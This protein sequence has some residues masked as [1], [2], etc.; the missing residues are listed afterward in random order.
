MVQAIQ[1]SMLT[2]NA[3]SALRLDGALSDSAA[4]A[5]AEPSGLGFG[6]LLNGITQPA[7]N[8]QSAAKLRHVP[9]GIS[10]L[11]GVSQALLAAA[12]VKDNAASTESAD[13]TDNADTT[14][15]A[16]DSDKDSLLTSSL[17]GQIALK[18]KLPEPGSDTDAAIGTDTD[19]V[20]EDAVT[21]LPGNNQPEADA[22]K[23]V[24]TTAQLGQ[25]ANETTDIAADLLVKANSQTAGEAA[26][27][28]VTDKTAA[29]AGEKGEAQPVAELSGTAKTNASLD[30]IGLTA[31]TGSDSY[32]RGNN[33]HDGAKAVIET[34]VKAD[35]SNIE[36]DDSSIKAGLV[37]QPAVPSDTK[38][39]GADNP[40]Q[41]AANTAT[42]TGA[43]DSSKT[44]ADTA[45]PTNKPP[46][47]ATADKTDNQA[48][49]KAGSE[50]NAPKHDTQNASQQSS[51]QQSSSQQ[52]S[53]QNNNSQQPAD[54]SVPDSSLATTK[55]AV[56]T[57]ATV[58]SDTAFGN[59]LQLA[60]QRQQAS[61]AQAL[62]R[63][64]AEQLKQSLN[65]L[66]QDAAG[67]LRERVTLMVRQNIQIAEIRLDP[68]GLGQMQI[69]IDMQQDQASV[70]FIVQQSQAKELL[71][72]QLPRLREML[73]QQGIQLTE[74]QVQQ[75]SQ[76]E[77]QLAQRD[78]NNSGRNGKHTA[79]DNQDGLAETVQ[80]K[81][82]T[83]DRLV[84]YYA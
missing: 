22:T 55:V 3:D 31:E 71:E 19:A 27:V 34:A 73:Q 24:K 82:K 77:R 9:A 26:P 74:G 83:S 75:Q 20:E 45:A 32:I 23:A 2:T 50:Q 46:L 63:P 65:L 47:T 21:V 35:D 7:T 42:A 38:K 67:Q 69:K 62:A 84:D 11:N 53:R 51:W 59:A 81:V 44:D 78:S 70:Q 13:T 16:A 61:P 39:A 60:E 58:R 1:L 79:D 37:T 15:S 5:G 54:G 6:E 28:K 29:S 8:S 33:N 25:S 68:A 12:N 18:D 36:A 41:I 10:V 64:L 49:G 66:Q 52:G 14:D 76:Q 56:D 80:L 48:G 4:E 17:L 30:D 72:Q 43:A 40:S 57:S